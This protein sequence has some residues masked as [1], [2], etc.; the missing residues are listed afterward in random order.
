MN[1]V[2]KIIFLIA[3]FF[4]QL[5][6]PSVTHA[7][8]NPTAVENNKFGIHIINDEDLDDASKLVNSSGGD[9]GYVTFVV[10]EDERDVGRWQKIFNRARKL[11]LIPIVRVATIQSGGNWTKP[12]SE[13][14]GE[15]VTFFDSLNWVVKNRY[16]IVGNEPNHATEWGGEV[17]PLEYAKYFKSFSSEPS[18]I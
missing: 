14:V 7:I 4:Y 15:W 17:N 1:I 16:V 10:R 3:I 13:D 11:H 9:W 6:S 2:V 8:E 12:V 5:F 18:T